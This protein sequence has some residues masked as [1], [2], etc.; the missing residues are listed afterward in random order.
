MKI[1]KTLKHHSIV[2][3]T[4]LEPRVQFWQIFLNSGQTLAIGNLKRALNFN[5][6]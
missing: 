3:T 6:F 5:A 2:F 4:I 1:K